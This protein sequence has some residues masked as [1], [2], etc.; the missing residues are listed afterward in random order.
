MKYN[1]HYNKIFCKIINRLAQQQ[2]FFTLSVRL[3]SVIWI[4]PVWRHSRGANAKKQNKGLRQ[5]NAGLSGK[6]CWASS[7]KVVQWP[8]KYCKC[9][10]T[11]LALLVT[12]QCECCISAVYLAIVATKDEMTAAMITLQ[13]CE[14]LSHSIINCA[15]KCAAFGTWQAFKLVDL[16][17]KLAILVYIFQCHIPT[18]TH[19]S[20]TR[21]HCF[22]AP[23]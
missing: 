11:F 16:L 13:H 5:K 9:K 10:S 22:A 17:L 12:L 19:Q 23:S 18:R 8:V 15:V 2:N 14:I 21:G 3:C 6:K 1:V 20:S 7:S 4:G